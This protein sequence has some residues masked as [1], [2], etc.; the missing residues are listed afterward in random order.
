MRRWNRRRVRRYSACPDCACW[1]LRV[2]ENGKFAR[3]TVGI[4][5]VENYPPHH[6][7]NNGPI[8]DGSGKQSGLPDIRQKEKA[9]QPSTT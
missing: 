5:Y 1:S 6:P 2:E 8:C 7:F 9:C 3:H 4:G